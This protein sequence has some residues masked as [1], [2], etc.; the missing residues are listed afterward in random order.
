MKRKVELNWIAYFFIIL[1]HQLSENASLSIFLDSIGAGSLPYLFIFKAS[2]DIVMAFS[3]SYRISLTRRL[4]NLSFIIISFSIIIAPY[5]MIH[6]LWPSIASFILYLFIRSVGTIITVEWGA[7]VVDIF[8][9]DTARTK[10]PVIYTASRFGGMAAGALLTFLSTIT[11]VIYI[12]TV[13]SIIS[14]A[15]G[16]LAK[17]LDRLRNDKVHESFM[18]EKKHINFIGI[19]SSLKEFSI[20]RV[21]AVATVMLA[22]LRN[23]MIYQYGYVLEH[24]FSDA[25]SMAAFLGIYFFVANGIALIIQIFILPRMGR[26]FGIGFSNFIY[27]SA[28]ILSFLFIS[29]YP[30][31]P[32]ALTGRFVENEGKAAFKTPF[33]PLF[34][35][36]LSPGIRRQARALILGFFSPIGAVISGLLILSIVRYSFNL[37]SFIS[38]I[39]ASLYLIVTVY[40]AIIYCMELLRNL[41]MISQGTNGGDFDNV[42]RSII[43]RFNDLKRAIERGQL[44]NSNEFKDISKFLLIEMKWYLWLQ[45]ILRK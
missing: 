12:I 11:N 22:L 23:L 41:E 29:I 10:L 42:N 30:F 5:P 3:Y 7:Q 28:F 40:Q 44:Q 45:K 13:A 27:A 34:Y 4:Y 9:R 15:A 37:I 14:F 6:S 31:L 33:S 17:K 43:S 16:F 1:G 36:V 38:I 8:K 24:S 25:E 39:I 19:F 21:L 35:D 2:A 32:A 26:T 18:Y 20:V